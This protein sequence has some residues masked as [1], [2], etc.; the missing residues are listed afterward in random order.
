[1]ATGQGLKEPMNRIAILL[2]AVLALSAVG[3]GRA[4]AQAS[5]PAAVRVEGRILDGSGDPLI[6]VAVAITP[7]DDGTPQT[8]QT[9]D[10]GR[11]AF[12]VAPGAYR[13]TLNGVGQPGRVVAPRF[14]VE[15]GLFTVEADADLTIAL[16]FQAVTV[17][18]QEQH[19]LGLSGFTIS[20]SMTDGVA[21]SPTRR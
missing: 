7:G 13:F 1:M 15:S 14:E 4:L 2:H 9:N 5:D 17:R 18:V 16:P 6:G 3:A 10:R 19:G 11:F 21:P 12:D 8:A 20:P